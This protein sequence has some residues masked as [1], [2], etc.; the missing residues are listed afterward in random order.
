MR[1]EQEMEM[2][3]AARS[4]EQSDWQGTARYEVLRRIG[5]GGMGVVYEA[6]DRERHQRVALKTLLHF[7]PAAFYLFKQEFRALADV[8]H[9]NLVRLYELV[10]NDGDRVFF[11]MELVHGTDL[12][13]YVRKPGAGRADFDL[14]RD[15][16]RQLAE[17]VQALHAMGKLHRD[18][19]PSNVLVTPEGRVVLLDFG[20]ATEL[21]RVADERLRDEES[22]V[23]TG[24]YMAP[25]QAFGDVPTPAAD[26]Y[27][28][29]VILYEALVG[30]PPFRGSLIELVELKEFTDPRAP[31][32]CVEGIPQD[33]DALCR[34]LL[35]RDPRRRPT[36]S[37]I[38]RQL[39]AARAAR[40]SPVAVDSAAND[41]SRVG[42]D[43]TLV[44]ARSPRACGA[45]LIGR[46]A[47]L[48]ALR[49]AFLA[50][51]GG[52]S[53]TVHL[54][55]RAGIGKSALLQHFLDGLV[56]RGEA[57]VL[58]GRA[59]ERESVPYKAVDSLVDGLS[60]YLMRLDGTFAFPKEID[61]LAR[62]FPVLRRIPSV[63][64][65]AEQPVDDPRGLRRVAFGALRE[66]LATLATSRPLVLYVD[67]V[68]WGDTDSVALLLELVRP[69]QA[70][71]ILLLLAH[72]EE[73]RQTAAFLGEIRR[74]WPLGAEERN[75]AIGPLET[76]D[77]KR[78]A[79]ALLGHGGESA[80]KFADA[81]AIESGGSPFL[82]E[83]LAQSA[84]GRLAANN[85][86][87]FT[88]EQVL[89]ERLATLPEDARRLLE[90]VAIAGRP[91]PTRVVGE[92]AGIES[93][94]HVVALLSTL[95]FVRPGLRDG[96]EVVEPIHDRIRESIVAQ[97][98]SAAVC[99]YHGQLAR[100]LEA[101]SDA[102][103]EAVAVHLLGAGQT[104]RAAPFAQRA[105][106]QA[107]EKLAFD[108]AARLFRLAIESLSPSAPQRRRLRSSLGEV[109][110]WAGR[111]EEAGRAYLAAAE[112]APPFERIALERAA[113]HHLLNAGRI[114]EGERV[115]RRVLANV[116]IDAPRSPLSAAFWLILYKFRLMVFGLRFRERNP[117]EVRADDRARIDALNVASVGM[118]I[119]SYILGAPLLARHLIEAL[120]VGDRSQVLRAAIL[121][122][123]HLTTFGGAV[124]KHERLV[125]ATIDRLEG[126][127]KGAQETAVNRASY[128]RG[129]FN[130]GL[131]RQARETL[132]EA[133]ANLPN[134][135]A[136]WHAQAMVFAVYSLL[137]LGDLVEV[138][139]RYGR[140][141][142]DAEQRGDLLTIVR[143]Q[144]SPAV[145]LSLAADD[146]EAARR[147]NRG[148]IWTQSEFSTSH[149]QAMRSDAEIAL[150]MG[151]GETAYRLLAHDERA[152]KES[153]GLQVQTVRALT[154]FVR[155]R[156]AIASIHAVPAR[157]VARIAEARRLARQLERE[158]MTWTAPLAAIL[159]ATV[160]NARGDRQ[161]AICAL[162]TAAHLAQVADMSLYAA[163]A[164]Y[165]LGLAL[166]GDEGRKLVERGEA[167][168]T[169]QDI[170]APGRFAAMIVPGPWGEAGRP[171][172]PTVRPPDAVSI[173]RGTATN[174][175]EE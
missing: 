72:R 19:K 148:A 171:P 108:Q 149:W 89:G 95:R 83:E 45:T 13:S 39:G 110:G 138:R 174:S 118:S 9:R 30:A 40:A 52:G 53:V 107:A 129:L 5:R 144:T 125:N 104:E 59:Y 77:A 3:V 86:V 24:T 80:D 56:E 135:R 92:A 66:L 57:T 29:G 25:E 35:D 96:R 114:D 17:G 41:V 134:R 165:Q 159:T 82:V 145:L 106:E 43:T 161:G 122:A 102:D 132:D 100:V 37:E 78:L 65:L 120:R 157:R 97:I 139:R 140:M 16:M 153:L 126:R 147:Q 172:E 32:E 160:A 112:G 46:E 99:A 163:A 47:H 10:A 81:L 51:R 15:A 60:R 170:R 2:P 23:G 155:G 54:S 167:S 33:L 50:V 146:P 175:R 116:G 113:S 162:R 58:R 158:R 142:A 64:Q 124:S 141:L 4:P 26:W 85:D 111:G 7:D 109:L 14:L 44:G 128:G 11:S 31:S 36:G 68:Q 93:T 164:L 63:R 49:E 18:I 70:P 6:R 22:I 156:A 98:S 119:C 150:Y 1:Q 168:M 173:S 127:D 117:D 101:G 38:V 20:L 67:D 133:C 152:L 105:A 27:S 84:A 55:G 8:N 154:A 121:Y 123:N 115:L 91:M 136:G 90:I 103:P 169:S 151:D 79:L 87:K 74:L 94:D 12:L 34:A 69:P 88:L 131:W 75:L 28:L 143:L 21:S 130:R 62:L 73:D 76:K 61:A 42:R 166:G 71:P 48:H 137:V